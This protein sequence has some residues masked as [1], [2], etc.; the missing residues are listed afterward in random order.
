MLF[1][2]ATVFLFWGH[3]A[4]EGFS[5]A[6][7]SLAVAARRDRR[8]PALL[9]GARQPASRPRVVPAVDAPVRRQLGVGHVGVRARRRVEAR[10]H[11]ASRRQHRRPGRGDVPAARRRDAAHH[12]GRLAVDAQPG[13]GAAL[14]VDQ[15][16]RRRH[17]PLLAAARPSSAATRSSG[18]TS[19][20]ATSTTSSSSTRSRS[21]ATSNP[22]SSSSPGSSH[23]RSTSDHQEYKV[24]DAALGI[25][26]RGTYQVDDAV[27]A[28]AVVARRPHPACTS[29]GPASTLAASDGVDE[30][31]MVEAV[32]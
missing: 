22:A 13:P 18:S 21:A 10:P 25:I 5:V 27:A 7:F 29:P 23:S 16:P 9:P 6:D 17:R 1:A 3:P 8:R 15:A 2:F 24:I 12:A 26:E 20:T 32:R 11:H 28:A 30:P 31:E 4:W 19:A 14:D